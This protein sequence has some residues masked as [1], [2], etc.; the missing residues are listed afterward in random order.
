MDV[1]EKPTMTPHDRSETESTPAGTPGDS[2][3][4]ALTGWEQLALFG[5]M[6]ATSRLGQSL[7]AFHKMLQRLWVACWPLAKWGCATAFLL[8]TGVLAFEAFH[9][10][11]WYDE[12]CMLEPAFYMSR[13][14]LPQSHIDIDTLGVVPFVLNY[15]LFM[16]LLT[17]AIRLAG[18]NFWAIRGLCFSLVLAGTLFVARGLVR[19]RILDGFHGVLFAFLF[20]LSI[21]ASGVGLMARPECLGVFLFALLLASLGNERPL[22]LVGCFIVS[23]LFPWNGMQWV[24]LGGIFVFFLWLFVGF[25]FSRLCICAA[26]ML[27]GLLAELMFFQVTGTWELYRREIIRATGCSSAIQMATDHLAALAHG[28]VDWLTHYLPSSFWMPWL[29]LVAC[30]FFSRSLA[31][32]M[33]TRRVLRFAVVASPVALVGLAL[34]AHLL[35]GYVFPFWGLFAIA[36]ALVFRDTARTFPVLGCLLLLVLVLFPMRSGYLAFRYADD[37]WGARRHHPVPIART[38][39]GLVSPDDVVVCNDALYYAVRGHAKDWYPL[40]RILCDGFPSDNVTLLAIADH[41]VRSRKIWLDHVLNESLDHRFPGD[42]PV[43]LPDFIR[44]LEREWSCSFREIDTSPLRALGEGGYR[45]FRK[46]TSS[47]A[48]DPS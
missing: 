21:P 44:L 28:N 19:R 12:T 41:P 8:W 33:D 22:A 5:R 6:V 26:G 48:L 47:D 14:G 4:S 45:C 24:F 2:S 42:D 7:L 29:G 38:L 27:A 3:V 39:S 30:A 40:R 37:P 36:Y 46:T 20:L 17:G 1:L 35:P 16:L 32:A 31:L 11:P 10:T 9:Y 25:R 18:F 34:L 23:F 43:P 13:G 15:P